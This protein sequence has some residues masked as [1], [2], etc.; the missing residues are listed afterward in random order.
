MLRGLLERWF[1]RQTVSTRL[2]IL[3]AIAIARAALPEAER[4]LLETATPCVVDQRTVWVVSQ[5][6]IGHVLV[7]QIDDET[8]NVSSA[9]R[10]GVR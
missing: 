1:G 10:V 3:E 5:A 7:V 4:D 9:R 2:S 6:A 8:G